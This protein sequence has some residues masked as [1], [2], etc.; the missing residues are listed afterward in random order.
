MGRDATSGDLKSAPPPPPAHV[1]NEV[2]TIK[3]HFYHCNDKII[4]VRD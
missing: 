4:I 2:H 1:L 3:I